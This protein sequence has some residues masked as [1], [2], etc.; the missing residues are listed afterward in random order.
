MAREHVAVINVSLVGPRNALLER[1]VK[2]LVGRGY[3]IVAAVG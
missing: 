3:I 2:T 1:V